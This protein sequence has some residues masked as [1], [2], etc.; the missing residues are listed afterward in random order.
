MSV[1]VQVSGG[2]RARRQFNPM[3]QV[4]IEVPQKSVHVEGF[5]DVVERIRNISFLRVWQSPSSSLVVAGSGSGCN[6]FDFGSGFSGVRVSCIRSLPRQWKASWIVYMRPG[7]LFR[8]THFQDCQQSYRLLSRGIRIVDESW[9]CALFLHA[10]VIRY[11]R[12]LATS[13]R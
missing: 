2:K 12:S 7:H 11:S 3:I 9:S 4:F 5:W 1:W 6:L 13:L 10:G 8:F